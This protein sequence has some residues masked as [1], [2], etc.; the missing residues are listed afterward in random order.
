MD[1]VGF[2]AKIIY[3]PKAE[4]PVCIDKIDPLEYE[5]AVT[6]L[7]LREYGGMR[8][9]SAAQ[10]VSEN[11]EA[12]AIVVSQDGNVTGFVSS[13]DQ[14]ASGSVLAFARLELTLF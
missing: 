11:R 5:G 2:G 13:D 14:E 9:Q 1:V 7:K 4:N 12:I 6:E 3:D 8:H 10:F